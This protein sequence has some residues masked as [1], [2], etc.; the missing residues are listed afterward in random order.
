MERRFVARYGEASGL[1]V[2]R[3]VLE[4][5]MSFDI[6][7]EVIHARSLSK[8]EPPHIVINAKPRLVKLI[9]DVRVDDS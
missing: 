6:D 5:A 9:K 3:R 4:S 7:N 2:L 8:E 1:V